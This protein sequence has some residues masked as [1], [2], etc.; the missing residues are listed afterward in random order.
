M[1]H[2]CAARRASGRRSPPKRVLR[3]LDPA[4][5]LGQAAFAMVTGIAILLVL[6]AGILVS[7]ADQHDP[8]VQERRAPAPGLPRARGR[9]STP[10][11]RPST[12][13]RT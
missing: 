13:T 7:T 3:R 9:A 12:T 1:S 10:T 8:L 5:E 6:T 2:R 4:A 11:S